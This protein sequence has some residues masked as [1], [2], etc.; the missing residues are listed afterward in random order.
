MADLTLP[1]R[2]GQNFKPF[3]LR[4]GKKAKVEAVMN[5]LRR[6]CPGSVVSLD[7]GLAKDRIIQIIQLGVSEAALLLPVMFSQAS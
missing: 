7:I 4:V 2:K 1:P 6:N 5:L 3:K